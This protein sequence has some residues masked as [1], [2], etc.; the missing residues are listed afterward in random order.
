[1]VFVNN[2]TSLQAESLV[3]FF[4]K[5]E[6]TGHTVITILSNKIF[7]TKN[8][9][10]DKFFIHRATSYKQLLARKALDPVLNSFP[11]EQKLTVPKELLDEINSDAQVITSI[12][13][14]SRHSLLSRLI[15]FVAKQAN[16]DSALKLKIPRFQ[17]E[18][19]ETVEIDGKE[20]RP[21][22][23]I[24][25]KDKVSCVKMFV[26]CDQMAWENCPVEP[27][28]QAIHETFELLRNHV[29][30]PKSPAF[31][32]AVGRKEAVV[33]YYKEPKED[34]VES[35]DCFLLSSVFEVPK[36]RIFKQE[37]WEALLNIMYKIC[38][39]DDVDKYRVQDLV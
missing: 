7:Y 32:V 21:D 18:E 15:Y 39:V 4:V 9:I 2:S 10:R 28:Q 6:S 11:V 37:T 38:L 27:L 36:F 26:V 1:V 30:I 17:V 31:G 16:K 3:K 13:Y 24:H 33:C 5:S 29:N 25:D 14:N 22:F 35:A 8:I 23:Q 19:K 34:E 12:E 20:C